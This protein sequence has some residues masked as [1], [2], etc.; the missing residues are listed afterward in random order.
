MPSLQLSWGLEN[1]H[2]VP[3]FGFS[4]LVVIYSN[5]LSVRMGAVRAMNQ[6]GRDLDISS[7]RENPTH[8]R[9]SLM[10]GAKYV[11]ARDLAV[12]LSYLTRMD[13]KNWRWTQRRKV[14]W[15][16]VSFTQVGMSAPHVCRILICEIN[17]HFYRIS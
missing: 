6:V 10:L 11:I 14:G 4:A 3:I 16:G 9:T 1:D 12:K 8:R 5:T 17:P 15:V 7:F 2:K 13:T